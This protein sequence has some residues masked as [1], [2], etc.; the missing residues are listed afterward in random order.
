MKHMSPE[1]VA[2]SILY[3]IESEADFW[4]INGE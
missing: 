1:Y 2:E 3:L 4:E